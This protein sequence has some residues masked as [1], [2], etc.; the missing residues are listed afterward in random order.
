MLFAA[1]GQAFRTR[2]I[3]E[4]ELGG[5]DAEAAAALLDDA[6]VRV[7]PEVAAELV[8]ATGGNPLALLDLP[9]RLSGEQ[10]QG[11]EPLPHPMPVDES[12]ENVFAAQA[13]SLSEEARRALVL[14]ATADTRAMRVITRTGSTTTADFEE[15]EDAG[16]LRIEDGI[17]TFV[18]PLMRSAA[19]QQATAAER[20]A[21]HQALADGFADEGK[22]A[23]RRA[24][25]AAEAT[26]EPD[27]EVA[28]RLER[29]GSSASDRRGHVA[30]AA[31]FERAARLTPDDEHRARRLYLA[32]H[33]AWLAGHGD[34]A[35]RLL[36][37]AVPAG[38]DGLLRADVSHLQG[39]IE[40]RRDADC[41]GDRPARGRGRAGRAARRRPCRSNARDGGGG[42]GGRGSP[43][44]GAAGGLADGGARRRGRPA[45]EPRARERAARSRRTGGSSRAPRPRSVD[46]RREQGAPARP[47]VDPRRG[48][49]ARRRRTRRR[50]AL[51]ASSSTR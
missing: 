5:L 14:A 34:R 28:G 20:R 15:C 9:R 27:E 16:L 18:H 33:S 25:H 39:R 41:R 30:A 31:M 19:Y 22:Y 45:R 1:R 51:P 42:L 10:L 23:E 47:G 50:R 26:M 6:D 2:G 35:L 37:D 4:L 46:A 11:A 21:A 29:A 40:L 43:R 13:R 8:A 17:V 48:R 7:S 44:A 49:D 38:A 3:P 32:A 24:W 12:L 36:E